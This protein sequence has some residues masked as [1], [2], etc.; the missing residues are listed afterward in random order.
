VS[1]LIHLEGTGFDEAFPAR[2]VQYHH[3]LNDH[4][5]LTQDAIADLADRLPRKSVI[6]DRANQP[7]LVPQ[8]GPPRGAEPRPGDVIRHLDSNQ[9]WL[10][11]LNIEHDPAYKELMDRVLDDVEPYVVARGTDMR[12]RVGF[13]FVS[14]PNSTTPAH[15]DIEHSLIMQV[16]GQKTLSFG[17]FPDTQAE[18]HEVRRYWEGSH[19]RIETLPPEL[20]SFELQPGIGGYIPPIAPHWV[21]NGPAISISVT[22]TFFTRETDRESLVHAFNARVQRLHVSP[23]WPGQSRS[24]DLAKATFMRAYSLRRHLG[25][26]G[27]DKDGHDY[28]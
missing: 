15:F 1:A 21:K 22:L 16:R 6:C 25:L 3:A 26:G 8:G 12:R 14:S 11:L 24:A 13:L 4:P 27:K 9:S 5:L 19:G 2:P 10:T 7:L 17:Q 23:R 20:V 28:G 18:R